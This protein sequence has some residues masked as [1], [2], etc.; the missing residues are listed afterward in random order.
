[1]ILFV[2]AVLTDGGAVEPVQAGSSCEL[3]G[4]EAICNRFSLANA[5]VLL[6]LPLEAEE[7]HSDGSEQVCCRLP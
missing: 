4:E 2:Q 7:S 1:M 6:K 5:F 3:E